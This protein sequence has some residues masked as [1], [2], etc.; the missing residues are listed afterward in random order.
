MAWP[1]AAQ[2]NLYSDQIM[3]PR[4]RSIYIE[5]ELNIYKDIVTDQKITI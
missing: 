1:P 2:S 3:T 5:R 4:N